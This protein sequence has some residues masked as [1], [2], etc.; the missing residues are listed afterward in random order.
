MA[1]NFLYIPFVN[2]IRFYEVGVTALPKYNVKQFDDYRFEDRLLPWQ[3]TEL[4]EQVWQVD[5]IINL[6]FE[7]TFDPIIISL[8]ND[9]GTAVITLPALIGLANKFLP[10][11]FSF[12]VAMALSS[13]P[14]GCYQVKIVAGT[15][16]SQKTYLSGHQ[17]ISSM[18]IANSLCLEYY[19]S[20]FHQDVVF[21][22]GI[23]FQYRI[24]G[25]LGFL[26]PG[27]KDELYRDERWNPALLNSRTTRQFPVF[28]GNERGITDD[29]I[30]LLNRIWS[31]DNVTIDK[32]A[33]GIADNGKFE[34]TGETD[35]SKRG[36]KL[37]LEEGIN[38]NSR[39]FTITADTTK[40]LVTTIIVDASVFGDTSNQGSA[41]TVPVYNITE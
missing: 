36:L 25:H 14:A 6:Q 23:K 8:V 30:D 24:F 2:P 17:Y 31:C 9:A 29:E 3:S 7:S 10:N 13:A 5:D 15:G 18:P 20:R 32:K 22:T 40:K 21:E 4:Y 19:N 41:N 35:Y 16:S 33:F 34:F 39:A 38:R 28:F 1:D 26:D 27:R 37:L 12:E 11:T